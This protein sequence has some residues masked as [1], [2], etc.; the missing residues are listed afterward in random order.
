[1]LLLWRAES[2]SNILGS[3][4]F[5]II[6]H[7]F[8]L[9][10][11]RKVICTKPPKESELYSGP[12]PALIE[13]EWQ[14]FHSWRGF[15]SPSGVSWFPLNGLDN[16]DTLIPGDLPFYIFQNKTKYPTTAIPLKHNKH[17]SNNFSV[18]FLYISSPQGTAR[19][20]ITL[21]LLPPTPF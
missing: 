15:S 7:S 11:F 4:P 10:Y 18:P 19:N 5:S 21:L 12:Y 13:P 14:L 16:Q 17:H 20:N 6:G 8:K 1:M 9:T 3:I 2:L